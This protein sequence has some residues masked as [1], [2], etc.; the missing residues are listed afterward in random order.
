MT[1][2]SPPK[3]SP[4]FNLQSF[5][6]RAILLF[7]LMV[8]AA[9][10]EG[11]GVMLL[12]PIIATLSG[13]LPD[14]GPLKSVWVELF[15]I[16]LPNT[17]GALIVIFLILVV[18]RSLI[19][20]FR[21][22]LSA[23]LRYEIVDDLRMASFT[24]LLHVEWRWLIM[25]RKSDHAN[26]LLTDVNRIGIALQYGIGMLV[27]LVT[28][29][30][31]L[32]TAFTIS[33]RM[34]LISSI[35]GGLVFALISRK[36][37]AVKHMGHS[38]GKA[39][40]TLH[41]TVEDALT[42][43]KLTKILGNAHRHLSRLCDAM[44][45]ARNHQISFLDNAA[46]YR[47]LFQIGGATLLASYLYFGLKYFQTPV[48][49]LV[50]LI[51]IFARL[52]PLLMATQQQYHHCLHA[53]PAFKETQDL[54]HECLIYSEPEARSAKTIQLNQGI[55]LSNVSIRYSGRELPALDDI[56]IYIPT[57][58]TT[59]IIG[60]SGAGKSTLA[61]V[62]MGLLTPDFGDMRI[63][64]E[65]AMGDT[66]SVWRQS[67]S[68]VPQEVFLFHDSIRNNLLW[69]NPK[70]SDTQLNHVLQLAAA[71][72][73]NQL[74]AGIDTIV[75]DDGIRLSGGERQRLALARA[76]LRK[77]SLLILDEATSALDLENEARIR[78]AIES[79]HGDLT[80]IIIGHRLMTLEHADQVIKLSN[81]R[82]E[83]IGSWEEINGA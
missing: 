3:F 18:I 81:G 32:I 38:L 48:P 15:K 52:T 50:T 77:P 73:V 71:D 17:V 66:L 69:G 82:I 9:L 23:A 33:W 55:T 42:G 51:F 1:A 83:Q 16:G 72:F 61:D 63:D 43:I 56:S 28:A 30:T 25:N 44:A 75:G 20:L 8:F 62:I 39:H 7:I 36:S 58:T 13:N 45:D 40:R 57:K 46:L 80:V 68:Y 53:F 60:H 65:V 21:D 41:V 2:M 10:T 79:M 14:T 64:D 49:E 19:Q 5:A 24:A 4:E 35:S 6:P 37:L 78:D 22:R 54:L 26:L 29:L 31:Y 76:L 70:A 67:V 27:S 59:A 11:F 12:V 34:A 47:M 74:P